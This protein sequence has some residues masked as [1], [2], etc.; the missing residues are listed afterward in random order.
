MTQVKTRKQR[1]MFTVEQKLDY[2]KLMVNEGYTNKQIIDISGA[3]PTAVARWKKQYL[4]ELDGQTPQSGKAM[5]P[6]Q[7]EAKRYERH[8]LNELDQGKEWAGLQQDSRSLL[9]LIELWYKLHGQSLRDGKRRKQLLISA[10][11]DM[12]NPIASKI[13]A[14]DFAYYREKKLKIHKPKTINNKQTYISSVFNELKRLN[15]I[16]YRNPLSDLRTI[17]VPDRELSYLDDNEIEKLFEELKPYKGTYLC[18]LICLTCGT[19]W[20]EAKNLQPEHIK[21]GKISLFNTKSGKNRYIPINSKLEEKLD[22]PLSADKSTFARCYK[23]SGVRKT[24]G[25]STHILRHTFASHFI[26]NGGDVLSL[27]KTLGH[28]TLAMTMRY[29]HLSPDHLNDV[30]KFAPKIKM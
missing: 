24:E 4:A 27:Q 30:L 5:T 7:Q 21:N 15:E 25:Q 14:K 9:D 20:G 19:R 12:N 10:A 22:L 28:S 6:E 23:K 18:A 16:D 1:V 3:G 26:M 8:F 17:K 2:V 11:N 13:T 29:A